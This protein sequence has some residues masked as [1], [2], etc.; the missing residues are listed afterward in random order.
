VCG[1]ALWEVRVFPGDGEWVLAPCMQCTKRENDAV[2][3]DETYE[4]IAQNSPLYMQVTLNN[5]AVTMPHQERGKDAV[6][7]FLNT[8]ERKKP[9]AL[10][11]WASTVKDQ[12][13]TGYGTG[14]T[15]LASI[16][17]GEMRRRRWTVESI[18][19]PDFLSQIRATYSQDGD[20]SEYTI[21]RRVI[22]TELLIID[23][24]G[25]EHVN[26]NASWFQEKVYRLINARYQ[27]GPLVITT[28]I[29]AS[30]LSMHLGSAAFSRLWEMTDQGARI[31]DM[32]GPDWRFR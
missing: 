13:W 28:N 24:L 2:W 16:I 26:S 12:G 10:V 22:Q 31:V 27:R 32:C 9:M 8:V 5:F 18:L 25:K 30:E 19:M 7:E 15:L 1:D 20:G 21:I 14:K 3:L 4:K 6:I 17:A 29:R 23:D 11:L